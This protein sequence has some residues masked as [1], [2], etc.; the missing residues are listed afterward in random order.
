M[1]LNYKDNHF[2]LFVHLCKNL[3]HDDIVGLLASSFFNQS[4]LFLVNCMWAS[5]ALELVKKLLNGTFFGAGGGIKGLYC[6]TKSVG[7]IVLLVL[8]TQNHLLDLNRL[9]DLTGRRMTAVAPERLQ[10]LL[11]K[12]GLSQLPGLP[13]LV[14]SPC[15]YEEHL[16]QQPSLLISTGEPDLWLEIAQ[17]DFR[18][19]LKNASAGRFG[20]P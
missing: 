2:L 17:Q 4:P 10:V 6:F 19:L 20:E 16:L 5:L 14:N 8:F 13:A 18:P 3:K 9:A 12:H 1:F 7:K 15:L 11:D